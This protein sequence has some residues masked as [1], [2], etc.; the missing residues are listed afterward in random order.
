MISWPRH[1]ADSIRN[2]LARFGSTDHASVAVEAALALPI[3]LGVGLLGADMQ[4]IQTERIRLENAAGAMAVNL[5]AQPELS[6]AG[7][8]ALSAAAM[9]GHESSQQLLILSV[10]QSGRVNW[11]LRR[12]GADGLCQAQAMQGRYT[13]AL[14]EDPPASD[15]GN[16]GSNDASTLSMVVVRACRD[17]SSILLSSGIVI[18]SL[19]DTTAIYRAGTVDITLDEALQNESKASGLAYSDSSQ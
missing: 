1:L 13:G 4:R 12:G 14:P 6:A 8:N 15:A 11:A 7:L 19:L 10:R 2:S 18:P 17:A 16:S 3:L 9:Q 5:A